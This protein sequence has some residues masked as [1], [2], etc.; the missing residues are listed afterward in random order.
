MSSPFQQQPKDKLMD[1]RIDE[2]IFSPRRMVVVSPERN[3]HKVLYTAVLDLSQIEVRINYHYTD[4]IG[5]PDSVLHDVLFNGGDMH[6][7]TAANAFHYDE[8]Q[9]DPK[10]SLEL[11]E[12]HERNAAKSLNFAMQYGGGKGAIAGHPVLGKL[13][14]DV[15]N[16]LLK[17]F[18]ET[19]AG[20]KAYQNWAI[21]SMQ[22]QTVETSQ[23]TLNY[24][25]NMYGRRYYD[26]PQ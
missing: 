18:N 3:G 13:S 26:T 5:Q 21:A 24:V 22:T 16:K 20:T 1:I 15:Q 6:T 7:I 19:R 23:G 25:E 4:Y 14:E 10:G 8:Y 17:A 12:K 11:V 9:K 2:E